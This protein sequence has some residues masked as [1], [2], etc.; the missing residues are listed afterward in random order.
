MIACIWHNVPVADQ[1]VHTRSIDRSRRCEGTPGTASP[2]IIV[3]QRMKCN[4][5][6]GR[7][8]AAVVG[9]HDRTEPLES[10]AGLAPMEGIDRSRLTFFQS[11]KEWLD[12][13]LAKESVAGLTGESSGP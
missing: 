12:K 10:P 8:V 9:I 2:I 7:D 4:R 6:A 13:E 5:E 1:F 3:V 11:Y